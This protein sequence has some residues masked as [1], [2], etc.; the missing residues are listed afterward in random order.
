[1]VGVRKA[2]VSDFEPLLDVIDGIT[3]VEAMYLRYDKESSTLRQR[4]IKNIQ[5]DHVVLF[6]TENQIIGFLEYTIQEHLRVWVYSV[7]FKPAH[8]GK[9]FNSLNPVF[10]GMKQSYKLPVHFTIHPRNKPMRAIVRYLRAVP[11]AEYEDGR[12]E[13]CV[14]EAS[15]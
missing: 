6:V 11:V 4:L 1:M 7:Y 14:K 9:T 15:I 3:T 5:E 2:V 8:R 12:I 13:Y 10:N